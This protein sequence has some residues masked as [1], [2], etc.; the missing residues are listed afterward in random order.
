[1]LIT[2]HNNG[3]N[4]SQIRFYQTLRWCKHDQLSLVQISE[5]PSHDAHPHE[6]LKW[7]DKIGD[8]QRKQINQI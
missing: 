5:S 7:N 6:D 4:C 2:W 3:D 8:Q 1:M